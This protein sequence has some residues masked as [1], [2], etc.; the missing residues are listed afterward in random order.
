[1]SGLDQIAALV[2]VV[3]VQPRSEV[4]IVPEGTAK[5][6]QQVSKDGNLYNNS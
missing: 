2:G 4:S 3:I 6:Y 1:M 5:A